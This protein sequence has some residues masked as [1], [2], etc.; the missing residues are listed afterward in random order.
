MIRPSIDAL[1]ET[2]PPARPCTKGGKSARPLAMG[3]SGGREHKMLEL[4]SFRV[5]YKS[6]T[7]NVKQNLFYAKKPYPNLCPIVHAIVLFDEL[8]NDVR[9]VGPVDSGQSV[10]HRAE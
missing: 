4:A 3:Q 2:F 1:L 9:V 8:R 6:N 10:A 5:H 7:S